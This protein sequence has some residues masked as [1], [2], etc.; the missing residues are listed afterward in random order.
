MAE[1]ELG[2]E[3]GEGDE[4][5][6]REGPFETISQ[7]Q[8]PWDKETKRKFFSRDC[9]HV[10]VI[11]NE[12]L[13]Q[14]HLEEIKTVVTLK[15]NRVYKSRY[16]RYNG[17]Y[18]IEA[19]RKAQ[20]HVQPK[21]RKEITGEGEDVAEEEAEEE[22][23]KYDEDIDPDEN[24]DDAEDFEEDKSEDDYG[25]LSFES[26]SI[27]SM[28]YFTNQLKKVKEPLTEKD[29][30]ILNRIQEMETIDAR[31]I[32]KDIFLLDKL[33]SKFYRRNPARDGEE[34][35]EEE[36]KEDPPPEDEVVNAF[37]LVKEPDRL[38][39]GEFYEDGEDLSEE[40]SENE[41][42]NKSD[43]GHGGS[44][45][46]EFEQM[47]INQ[48]EVDLFDDLISVYE[49]DSY[50]LTD[51]D[52]KHMDANLN[53]LNNYDFPIDYYSNYDPKSV[54][55]LSFIE[56]KTLLD[57]L[58]GPVPKYHKAGDISR[59]MGF[60]G[61]LD[62]SSKIPYVQKPK[63][64]KIKLKFNDVNE[65]GEYEKFEMIM[66]GKLT[67]QDLVPKSG[68]DII[69][70]NFFLKKYKRPTPGSLAR[71]SNQSI[72]QYKQMKIPLGEASDQFAIVR[73]AVPS[74]SAQEL[75]LPTV[76]KD[77]VRHEMQIIDELIPPSSE[78]FHIISTVGMKP[79][80]KYTLGKCND[81]SKFFVMRTCG[82][83][84]FDISRS[85]NELSDCWYYIKQYIEL[86]DKKEI[87]EMTT[88]TTPRH[89]ILITNF[90][91]WAQSEAEVRATI[92]EDNFLKRRPHPDY[93]DYYN[94]E[95][96]LYKI[97]QNT[98]FGLKTTIIF[99][100]IP[101]GYEEDVLLYIFKMAWDN[102]KEIP[103]FGHGKNFLPLLHIDDL[104]KVVVNT[105]NRR[106]YPPMVFA[107][108]TNS[109]N[110]MKLAKQVAA[111]LGNGRVVKIP[112]KTYT[113]RT[114]IPKIIFDLLQLN[115]KDGAVD[116][117]H[118]VR[119]RYDD[120]FLNNVDEII[121]ELKYLRN[122]AEVTI[123]LVGPPSKVKFEIAL[124]LS[125]FYELP[126]YHKDNI[127]ERFLAYQEMLNTK[128]PKEEE[129]AKEEEEEMGEEEEQKEQPIDPEI[130]ALKKIFES[131]AN[132]V[133]NQWLAKS[134]RTLLTSTYVKNH[135]YILVDFPVRS[136]DAFVL[137][138]Q[139]I[140]NKGH[141]EEEEEEDD[142]TV[143]QTSQVTF[144][145]FIFIVDAPLTY[146]NTE[147]IYCQTLDLKSTEDLLA[148]L[149]EYIYFRNTNQSVRDYI[150]RMNHRTYPFNICD[151]EDIFNKMIAILGPPKTN[152]GS[153]A[154]MQYL[155]YF[156]KF[157][158]INSFT[159]VH[160]KNMETFFDQAEGWMER[161]M[162]L[163]YHEKT[164]S[165]REFYLCNPAQMFYA[166]NR[167]DA[168]PIREVMRSKTWGYNV[169]KH[170]FANKSSV[171]RELP[172]SHP[173]QYWKS[174][175]SFWF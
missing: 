52:I 169:I 19:L 122:L 158:P 103:I 67:P 157:N 141:E 148:D 57:Y 36:V 173:R 29:R 58:E 12:E 31:R 152:N 90:L 174:L 110:L 109:V 170:H 79:E 7:Y 51:L 153:Q 23:D 92:N 33:Y 55:A 115:V 125:R 164:Y 20:V 86:M 94:L 73:R 113:E 111:K 151:G 172:S 132:N 106:L 154:F 102:E 129:E 104:A 168:T 120:P 162:D 155:K 70:E 41:S 1:E 76:I 24:D 139:K 74:P 54:K 112:S 17:K 32:K 163:P 93:Q 37:P 83:V 161:T 3:F 91:S 59:D 84:I 133:N 135:G 142:K 123:L 27:D 38:S 11:T 95:N 78:I 136:K 8:I 65:F 85:R 167:Y 47:K 98:L 42:E 64:E 48:L 144:P 40:G 66:D 118:M 46:E 21:K 119:P 175:R 121:H 2:G 13:T 34:M 126:V 117:M 101:I 128:E 149:E 50:Y 160:Q 124:L 145:E 49:M 60:L 75:T 138:E 44:V 22:S 71:V 80:K 134:L 127:A 10:I 140:S 25:E 137:F 63:K 100:G 61:K 28:E 16:D 146:V 14:K 81:E 69:W 88:V 9:G 68:V 43:H 116:T 26:D 45:D 87:T 4:L 165:L 159:M 107:V 114:C 6:I 72:L 5:G 15:D 89:L 99:S 166:R 150:E 56:Y 143:D 39:I 147:F 77:Y 105:V 156:G 53:A 96:F 97:G 30:L 130:I 82:T 62:R 18:I 35:E 108:G 171:F 131:K